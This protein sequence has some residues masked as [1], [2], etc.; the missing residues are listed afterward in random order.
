MTA[1]AKYTLPQVIEILRGHAKALGKAAEALEGVEGDDPEVLARVGEQARV[2]AEELWKIDDAV[3]CSRPLEERPKDV[4]EAWWADRRGTEELHHAT[5]T[6]TLLALATEAAA[7]EPH[8]TLTGAGER[9]SWCHHQAD[10]I[11]RDL[12]A[13]VTEHEKDERP[14][15]NGSGSDT[16]PQP[17]E[18]QEPAKPESEEPLPMDVFDAM[19]DALRPLAHGVRTLQAGVDDL[20][21]CYIDQSS[22]PWRLTRQGEYLLHD[23]AEDAKKGLGCLDEIEY[24]QVHRYLPEWCRSQLSDIREIV[25]RAAWLLWAGSEA[26]NNGLDVGS[27]PPGSPDLVAHI[28]DLMVKP[29]YQELCGKLDE[30]TAAQEVAI[31]KQYEDAGYIKQPNGEWHPPKEML[32]EMEASP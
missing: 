22:E 32:G 23:L 8:G 9:W 17:E 27:D 29:A 3:D 30:Y 20:S 11:S 28:V 26:A 13:W 24:N 5:Y 18:P 25:D 15:E 14:T 1:P 12:M 4:E 2:A 6:L 31:D 10:Q 16:V 21:R 7:T 19:A